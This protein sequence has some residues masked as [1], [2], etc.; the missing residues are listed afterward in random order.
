MRKRSWETKDGK[1]H[2]SWEYIVNLD[3]KPITRGGYRLK[4]EADA[5]LE[6]ELGERNKGTWVEPSRVTLAEFI[7]DEWLP[8]V[9]DQKRR[10]T[11][12]LYRRMANLHIIPEIGHLPLQSVR[13]K[14]VRDLYAQA[15]RGRPAKPAQA[16]GQEFAPQRPHCPARGAQLCR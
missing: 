13:P 6:F 2:T 10:T 12:D 5:A 16:A 3:P 9:D 4:G 15:A 11:A 1:S 14:D 7:T 8:M